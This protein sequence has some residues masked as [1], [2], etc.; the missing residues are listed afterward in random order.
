[1][2]KKIYE[3]SVKKWAKTGGISG[4]I[5]VSLIFSYLLAIGAISDVSYSGDSLPPLGIK[6]L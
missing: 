1:M 3:E 2:A 5:L 4:G 6:P